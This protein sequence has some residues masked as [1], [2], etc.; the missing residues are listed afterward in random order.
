MPIYN[1]EAVVAYW[2][3][4]GLPDFVPDTRRFFLVRGQQN[5]AYATNCE[6][7]CVGIETWHKEYRDLEGFTTAERI[8][9]ILDR[10]EDNRAFLQSLSADIWVRERCRILVSDVPSICKYRL[11]WERARR[12]PFPPSSLVWLQADWSDFE[13]AYGF[14]LMPQPNHTELIAQML[15]PP[16]PEKPS[17][18]RGSSGWDEQWRW[19][20]SGAR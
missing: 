6:Q 18:F 11:L 8:W 5:V 1:Y 12:S 13:K 14:H 2:A 17:A 20:W 19:R 9:V 4:R 7:L 15:K 3:S 10:R 16:E